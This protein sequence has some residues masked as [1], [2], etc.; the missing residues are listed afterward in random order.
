MEKFY[1]TLILLL[2]AISGFSQTPVK[3]VK[4]IKSNAIATVST[5]TN[6]TVLTYAKQI[7]ETSTYKVLLNNTGEPIDDSVLEM[8]NYHRSFEED[9]TWI[10]NE[11]IEILIYKAKK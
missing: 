10:V 9:K 6:I 7:P 3:T 11:D 8:I 1:T 5:D 2:C 4:E